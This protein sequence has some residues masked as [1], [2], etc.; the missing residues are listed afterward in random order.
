VI[1]EVLALAAPQKDVLRATIDVSDA[2]RRATVC[3]DARELTRAL[4]NVV[5]N[6]LDAAGGGGRVWITAHE[7]EPGA[8]GVTVAD[9][10]PG[11]APE[12]A[13]R[14]FDP[15]FTTKDAGTGL[16][17]SIVHSIAEAH[18]GRVDVKPRAGGGAAFTLV[19]PTPC[20]A[21]DPGPGRE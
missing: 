20:A 12:Q 3:G 17:L 11:I 18:G 7:V 2:A 9:N 13:Q 14:I 19:L 8:I 21:E 10:G 5:F 1:E 15:F 6:A 4:V 16:G